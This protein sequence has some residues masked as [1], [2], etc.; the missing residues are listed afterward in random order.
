MVLET[1]SLRIA[2]FE[3]VIK[4]I[5]N[6]KSCATAATSSEALDACRVHLQDVQSKLG[7]SG[8]LGQ[9]Q[10]RGEGHVRPPLLPPQQ[11]SGTGRADVLDVRGTPKNDRPTAPSAPK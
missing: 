7:I 10:Q 1:L 5:R 8:G 3:S 11:S 9:E 6:A 2:T 4:N